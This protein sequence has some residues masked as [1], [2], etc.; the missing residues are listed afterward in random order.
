MK[1]IQISPPEEDI[2][3]VTQ[4]GEHRGMYSVF[5]CGDKNRYYFNS[6]RDAS[7]FIAITNQFLTRTMY[8]ARLIYIDVLNKY[9]R[10][11]GYF[12]HDKPGMGFPQYEMERKCERAL[13]DIQESF[14]L[15][16]ERS[17]SPNGSTIVFN[18]MR[19]I[20]DSLKDAIDILRQLNLKRN[21]T[22]E[23]YVLDKLSD[24]VLVLEH[25]IKL[26]GEAEAKSLQ[27]QHIHKPMPP[28][29]V[30]RSIGYVEAVA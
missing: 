22:M 5:L 26:F 19:V 17:D 27:K 11:W 6:K 15:M 23:L 29:H 25:S 21:S 2:Q 8:K 18:K 9:H 3:P 14:N 16:N 30:L 4:F 1:R 10:D 24:D 12:E 20:T 7:R 13:N 28:E